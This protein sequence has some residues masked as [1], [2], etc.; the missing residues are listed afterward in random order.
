M[1][2][3]VAALGRLETWER[4]ADGRP[5]DVAV[6]QRAFRRI[7]FNFAKVCSIGFRSE[8]YFGRNQRL[9]PASSIA[10]RTAG[11]L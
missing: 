3:V 5:Q 9:A 10:R 8:L 6:R 11:L 1:A 4:R 2:K 7:A